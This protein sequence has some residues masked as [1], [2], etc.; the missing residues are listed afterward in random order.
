ML[1][2]AANSFAIE[3]PGLAGE[4]TLE[5]LVHP[6]WLCVLWR[7]TVARD[8]LARRILLYFQ[9]ALITFSCK[10]VCI[11]EVD[12]LILK[13]SNCQD[14]ERDRG[15]AVKNGCKAQRVLSYL[16]I[17]HVSVVLRTSACLN[18]DLKVE[19]HG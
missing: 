18:E 19:Q 7:R 4:R 13:W 9:C 12:F 17:R 14:R 6:R 11:S 2:L 15:V 5:Y 3:A 1:V 16:T 8:V 10:R